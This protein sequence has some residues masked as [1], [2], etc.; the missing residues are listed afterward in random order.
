MSDLSK[1]V[2]SLSLTQTVSNKLTSHTFLLITSFSHT[3]ILRHRMLSKNFPSKFLSEDDS[4]KCLLSTQ[5]FNVA[6]GIGR[7]ITLPKQNIYVSR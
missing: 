2:L 3:R 5:R 6:F 4:L 7:D 1:L